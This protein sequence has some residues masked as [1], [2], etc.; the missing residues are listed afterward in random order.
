MR[1]ICG[2]CSQQEK[3]KGPPEGDP[4]VNNLRRAALIA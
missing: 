3:K 1:D 4:A 2:I